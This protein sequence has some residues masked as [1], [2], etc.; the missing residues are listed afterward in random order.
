MQIGWNMMGTSIF[1]K[2]QLILGTLLVMVISAQIK[3]NNKIQKH[4]F[5]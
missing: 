3:V 2:Q 1:I 5:Y 4:G